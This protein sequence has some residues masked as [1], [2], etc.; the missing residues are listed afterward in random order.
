[1][2]KNLLEDIFNDPGHVSQTD[3]DAYLRGAA[4]PGLVRKVEAAMLDDDLCSDAMDGYAE[5]GLAV[6]PAFEDFSE[7]KKK[8]P[9]FD[10]ARI[11][12]MRPARQWL[13]V[14]IAAAAVAVAVVGYFALQNASSSGQKL[15]AEFYEV[16]ENDISLSRRGDSSEA[17]LQPDLRAAL[18]EYA[19]GS[20]GASLPAFEQATAAEP[21]NIAAQ[22][23][24]GLAYLESG[25]LP[26]ATEHLNAAAKGTGSYARKA[27]WYAILATLKSGD[28]AAA[29]QMLDGFLKGK[30]FKDGEA[31]ELRERF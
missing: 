30:G 10:G 28:K 8:L 12:P 23:F 6:L 27:Q 1:M 2:Q 19:T 16:Y 5:M 4:P 21:G 11:V 22:F 13:R 17:Q 25:D 18:G 15:Y 7:F 31:R 29:S 26:K 20:Y 3:M 9:E 14:A 24:A